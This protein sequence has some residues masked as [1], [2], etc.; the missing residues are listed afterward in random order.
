MKKPRLQQSLYLIIRGPKH[1][2]HKAPYHPIIL[3]TRYHAMLWESRRT[4][5]A[6]TV[7]SCSCPDAKGSNWALLRYKGFII[8]GQN[9]TQDMLLF[10]G[11]NARDAVK[12]LLEHI[13]ESVWYSYDKMPDW[14]KE[15]GVKYPEDSFTRRRIENDPGTCLTMSCQKEEDFKISR[16]DYILPWGNE[17][18]ES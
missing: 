2:N 13:S 6:H 16:E 7:L 4:R 3:C 5:E 10:D 18:N 8:D 14:V 1:Q 12:Q 17:S 15:M 9:E 11:L